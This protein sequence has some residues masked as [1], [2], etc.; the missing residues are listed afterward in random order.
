MQGHLLKTWKKL[1]NIS[2]SHLW[3]SGLK[4]PKKKTQ[5]KEPGGDTSKP[6]SHVGDQHPKTIHQLTFSRVRSTQYAI[7]N[8]A[9]QKTNRV[10]LRPQ[11]CSVCAAWQWGYFCFIQ[12]AEISTVSSLT[13]SR[14]K[15]LH[16]AS[17]QGESQW[18]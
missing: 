14:G 17:S 12:V 10:N 5:V 8:N 4:V 13:G 18:Y 2:N 3:I 11:R 1:T 7:K 9:T 15:P 6:A 16:L